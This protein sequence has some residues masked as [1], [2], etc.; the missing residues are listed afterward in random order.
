MLNLTHG[1]SMHSIHQQYPSYSSTVRLVKRWISAQMLHNFIQDEAV[2][3]IVAHLFLHPAPYNVTASP[4]TGFIR[5]LKLMATH[6]WKTAPLIVN[7]N[8]ELTSKYTWNTLK[9]ICT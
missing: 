1:V 3:L 9:V 5:F 7:F 8:G 2:E 6:N 4:Q